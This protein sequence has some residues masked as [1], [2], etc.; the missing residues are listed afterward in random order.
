[1]VRVRQNVFELGSDWA[2]PI[3]W[4]A[5]GVKAMKARPLADPTGWT[6]YAAIHGIDRWLWNFYSFTKP[7]EPAPAPQDVARFWDQCQHQSWY[8]LPWHRGYLMA[9]ETQIRAEIA[10]LGGPADDWALPYWNY[11]NTGQNRLPAAFLTPDW[12]DGKGDNPLFV[13]QRWGGLATATPYPIW[14][15]TNIK[16]MQDADFTVPQPNM[17]T[18]FGGPETGFSWSG[19]RS[20]G[21]ENNPHNMVHVLVGGQND[22]QTFPPDAPNGLA[23]QPLEGVMGDPNAAALDPIFYLHHSNIDRLWQSWNVFPTGKPRTNPTD[24]MNPTAPKWAGGPASTGE[25]A[26]CMPKPTGGYVTYTPSQMQDIAALGYAYDDLTPGTLQGS[27]V[28]MASAG[29]GMTSGRPTLASTEGGRAMSSAGPELMAATAD[30]PVAGSAP[31]RLA[32]RIEPQVRTRLTNSL[33]A[34]EAR[35][36]RVFLMLEN[37]TGLTNAGSF[38][39]YLGLPA[40]ADD[41]TRQ[42]HLAGGV[43]MFGLRKASLADGPHGG[44]G[45]SVTLEVSD[46]VD[47]LHLSGALGGDGLAVDLVPTVAIPDSAQ[48]RIGRISL[49]RQPA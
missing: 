46:I 4:Y 42:A 24:W 26:F 34:A 22:S 7:T 3:L 1:M 17:S 37:I 45:I 48:V 43:S 23:N 31:L 33:V 29:R 10:A 47:R 21:I 2:D 19:D 49:H 6:F 38:A 14:T 30:L 41:S 5:R 16:A 32:L 39:V 20:G 35:P 15:Q 44:G 25:R 36:D 28:S 11:F 8:F 40:D 9:L 12:P 13:T 18:G 27:A